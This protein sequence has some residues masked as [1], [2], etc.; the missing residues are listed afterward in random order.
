MTFPDRMTISEWPVQVA[1]N[2]KDYESQ[3]NEFK[4]ELMISKE[5]ENRM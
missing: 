3:E 5:E 1:W 2:S 4:T